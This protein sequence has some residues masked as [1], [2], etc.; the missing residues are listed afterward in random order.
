MRYETNITRRQALLHSAAALGSLSLVGHGSP[1][2]AK[3]EPMGSN[4]RIR[5]GV[6]G[7]GVRGKYLIGNLPEPARVTAICDCS[8]S[9][10]EETLKP[11]AEFAEVLTPFKQ[12]DADRCATYQDYRKMIDSE[13]LDAVIIATP[14]HHHTLA[15][16][17]ALDAGLDVYIEKPLTVSI[18][19]GRLLADKV[20]STR[21]VLQ[22]G[23]QQRTMEM[24]R[25]ACEFIREGGLGEI[26]E[27]ALPNY[28]GPIALQR[29]PIEA[30][31]AGFDWDLFLGPTPEIAHNRKLW[32]KDD[33]KVDGLLWRGWDLFQAYSGHLMTNWGAH[34]V[35][36]VQYALGQDDSGPIRVTPRRDIS[37]TELEADW[38]AKW[39]KKT[40]QPMGPWSQANRF[41]PVSLEYE[42]GTKLSLLPGIDNATF[43]GTRGTMTISRNKF[44][45]DPVDLV[46][47]APSLSNS[48]RWD[49]SGHV[50]RPHLQNWIECMQSRGKPNAPVEVGHRTATIC[51]LVNIARQLDRSL[52]WNPI[53][54]RFID[55]LEADQLLDRPRRQGFELP[56]AS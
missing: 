29:F 7:T 11:S 54:E 10:M 42:N 21:R 24:N 53:T 38:K 13:E 40:P 18:R 39:R 8:V 32:V 27:V 26:R 50:A 14:D 22:V 23:S 36:M 46:K 19:E 56:I 51:H 12:R 6:I 5:V 52:R 17:L 4:E 33:F 37:A 34:S 43:Y 16:M 41:Q 9:R 48:A 25:F 49:G 20:K 47:I 15:A 28:P 31:P 3:A 44:V 45:A 1:R 35:D 55:D 30:I 2:R